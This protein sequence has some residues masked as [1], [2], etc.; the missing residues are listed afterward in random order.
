[1]SRSKDK[2]IEEIELVLENV[3]VIKFKRDSLKTFSIEGIKRDIGLNGTGLE[4]EEVFIRIDSKANNYKAYQT[5][6]HLLREDV[7]NLPARK[8]FERLMKYSDIV[9]IYIKYT[10]GSSEEISV[11]WDY[12]ASDDVNS[13]QTNY[14]SD[15]SKDLYICISNNKTVKDAFYLD[16]DDFLSGFEGVS[17]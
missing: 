10:D 8:P 17:E 3:E 2:D 16:I 14:L 12:Y 6:I 1:M 15:A 9:C 4:A 7:E 11:S 13:Y 5:D